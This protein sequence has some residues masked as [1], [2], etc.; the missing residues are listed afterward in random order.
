M[1]Q[2]PTWGIPY[3]EPDDPAAWGTELQ[4]LAETTEALLHG[5][6]VGYQNLAQ[7]QSCVLT[8]SG[9]QG[10]FAHDVLS[11]IDFDT[12]VY[13]PNSP[14]SGLPVA[15]VV[16]GPAVLTPAVTSILDAGWYLVEA[17]IESDP[18]GTVTATSYRTLRISVFDNTSLPVAA[19]DNFFGKDYDTGTTTHSL[20]AM[21]LTR[22]SG[23]SYILVQFEHGNIASTVNV[24]NCRVSMTRICPLVT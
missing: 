1:K 17:F 2:T 22:M 18:T 21:G 3:P 13:A 11:T 19:V 6:D 14:Y 12:T 24:V 5:V 10:P 23:N 20:T 15:S 9:T 16:A 4:Y 7:P 8:I